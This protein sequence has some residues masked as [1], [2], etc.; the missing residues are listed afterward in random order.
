[1]KTLI[2]GAGGFIGSHL[3]EMM[4]AAGHKV[5]A[6][7]RYR[8]TSSWGWLDESPLRDDME[9]V[10]GDIR[11]S[12]CVRRA[13]AGCDAVFH[14]AALIGI[15]YSYISPQAYIK[16]NVE[17]TYN[18]L[19]AC[20]DLG[21]SRVVHA[22]TSEV[23]GTARYV[24]IDEEHPLNPQSPYAATKSA[25]DQLAIAYYRSFGLP[26]TVVRPFN[27]YGPRQSARAV[28]PAI[29]SQLLAGGETVQLGDIRPT[30]DLNFVTDTAEGFARAGL[31]ETT[32]GEVVNIGWGKEISI[33]DLAVKI[34]G[35]AGR[36]IVIERDEKRVRPAGSEVERLLA[37]AG[38]AREL[39][40]WSPRV[41]LSEGLETTIDWIAAHRS[42]YRENMY[43]L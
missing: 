11:D 39:T 12:D 40:G 19:E 16:T 34:A 30:R 29:V 21:V 22:S 14:L 31:S 18:V 3:S 5:R 15:P 4:V 7:V 13:V 17:G 9:V 2:T 23:Y 25:A 26:V 33:G 10:S 24:P 8:S 41:T 42:I 35:I 36:R 28:I 38:K 20:R 27:T 1:M 6:F 32:V 37:D 43:N